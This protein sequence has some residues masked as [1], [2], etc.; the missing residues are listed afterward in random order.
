VH[1]EPLVNLAHRVVPETVPY[2]TA[3]AA[4][5]AEGITGA[6]KVKSERQRAADSADLIAFFMG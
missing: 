1:E 6:R 5:L 2:V 3:Q 4:A